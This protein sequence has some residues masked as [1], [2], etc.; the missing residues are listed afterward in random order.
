MRWIR[1]KF[2]VSVGEYAAGNTY[3]VENTW[4]N[5]QLVDAQYAVI[6]PYPED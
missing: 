3:D 2:N 6:V 4:A 1:L 5:K